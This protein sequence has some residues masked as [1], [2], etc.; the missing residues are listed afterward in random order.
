MDV[1][2]EANARELS[3][4]DKLLALGVS[5]LRQALARRIVLRLDIQLLEEGQSLN[6]PRLLTS[7]RSEFHSNYRTNFFERVWQLP[8]RQFEQCSTILL[9]LK[10]VLGRNSED[11]SWPRNQTP[12][13]FT[14]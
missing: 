1:M 12:A 5:C 9:M 8:P 10:K 7:Q 14:S 13:A 6:R 4:G 2:G 3:G 11:Q